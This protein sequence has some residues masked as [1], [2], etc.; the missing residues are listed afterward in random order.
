MNLLNKNPKR[1]LALQRSSSNKKL[2]KNKEIY[3]L[4][5]KR[6][7]AQNPIL[8][9]TLKLNIL[10]KI[11]PKARL[12][13]F[14][15]VIFILA[16]VFFRS[17]TIFNIKNIEV[18][19]DNQKNYNVVNSIAQEYLGKNAF[20]VSAG[21]ISNKIKE[22]LS[23]VHTVFINKS[24]NG[25]LRIEVIEDVPIYY[26]VNNLG[27]YLI[28]QDGEVMEVIDLD[29]K[30]ELSEVEKLILDNK[31]PLD[32]DQVRIEYLESLPEEERASV[33]W[34]QIPLNVKESALNSLKD[35]LNSRFSEFNSK[36][37]SKLK[38]P[39]FNDMVG[40]FI[41]NNV[42]YKVLDR[43]SLPDLNFVSVIFDFFKSKNLVV[44]RVDWLSGYTIQVLLSPGTKI[45][46][47]TKR[48]SAEQFVD[49]N[50]LIYHGQ[51]NGNKT[52]DVRSKNYS[53]IN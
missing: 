15:F 17:T 51:V 32:S 25:S 20:L 18:I 34:R 38:E 14:L 1:K 52:I 47:S 16:V 53:V 9:A 44:E 26:L 21:S 46:L 24:L 31:L 2:S 29:F 33:D 30:V 10:S 41:P 8:K 13:G 4:A 40:S 27:I 49:L 5:K 19:V 12:V 6:Q 45:F 11:T 22:E 28:N 42:S 50:T 23:S 39:I 36:L 35:K 3:K 7:R 43:L 37:A 48:P